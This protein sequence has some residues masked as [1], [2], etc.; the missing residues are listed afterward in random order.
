[1]CSATV[2]VRQRGDI[3][4]IADRHAEFAGKPRPAVVL[5]STQFVTKTLTV[6]LIT[7][8]AV[9]APML[10]IALPVNSETGLIENSWA[11]IDQV[12]TVR[13]SRV[14]HGI[15]RLDSAKMLEISQALLV[16]LGIADAARR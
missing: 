5:Q 1:M 10:R 13:R 6:C 7:S 2:E 15:G 3:V 8:I 4:L 12:A 9:D 14:S 11:A 16:F